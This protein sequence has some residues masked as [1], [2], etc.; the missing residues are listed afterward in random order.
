MLASHRSVQR[1]LHGDVVAG[2]GPAIHGA[3]LSVDSQASGNVEHSLVPPIERR[4]GQVALIHLY[5]HDHPPDAELTVG[6]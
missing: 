4:L 6:G 1:L 5:P 2:R 3:L